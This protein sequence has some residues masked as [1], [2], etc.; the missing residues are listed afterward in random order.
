MADG[1]V[2]WCEQG[3]MRRGK[4]DE[5]SSAFQPM[6][7]AGQLGLCDAMASKSLAWTQTGSVV[8]KLMRK[9]GRNLSG[10][11]DLLQAF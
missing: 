5:R 9:P 1:R 6:R 4:Y 10:V 7:G 8:G 11:D 2:E 3:W